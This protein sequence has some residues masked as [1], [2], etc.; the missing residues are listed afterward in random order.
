MT[1]DH[2]RKFLGTGCRFGFRS[3]VSPENQRL[4][5][6]G[7]GVTGLAWHRT[8]TKIDEHGFFHWFSSILVATN[9]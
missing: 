5:T 9:L 8:G 1:A 4:L 3:F 7:K 2:A 6:F